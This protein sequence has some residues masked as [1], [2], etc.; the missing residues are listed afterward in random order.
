MTSWFFFNPSAAKIL[1]YIDKEMEDLQWQLKVC[2]LLCFYIVFA[3]LFV[4]RYSN[5]YFAEE[6]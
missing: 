6:V 5:G 4:S 2:F 1:S 3:Y